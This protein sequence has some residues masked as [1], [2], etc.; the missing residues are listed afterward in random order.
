VRKLFPIALVLVIAA[1]G[2]APVRPQSSGTN[3]V[4]RAHWDTGGAVSGTVTLSLLNAAGPDTVLVTK[5]LYNGGA[6]F[7]TVLASNSLYNVTL[8]SP[9]G[10]Q[11]VKFPFTT[12]L[13]NPANLGKAAI[14]LVF[15][16]TDRTL[17]SASVNVSM[18]F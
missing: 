16:S 8:T 2:S 7:T 1:L 18:S 15:Y 3:L 14:N 4:M 10:T 6:S 5:N 17:K 11:L 9:D 13:I 12:A